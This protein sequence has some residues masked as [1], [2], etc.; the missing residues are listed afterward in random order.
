MNRLELSSDELPEEIRLEAWNDTV[1]WH[2]RP[3]SKE[4]HS[5]RFKASIAPLGPFSIRDAETSAAISQSNCG[6]QRQL[7]D[8]FQVVKTV[9]GGFRHV[10]NGDVIEAREGDILFLRLSELS[11]SYNE[12]RATRALTGPIDLLNFDPAK[13]QNV[14]RFPHHDPYTAVVGAALDHTAESFPDRSDASSDAVS[15]SI[16]QMVN[17]LVLNDRTSAE[18]ISNIAQ[19]RQR[20]A[21]E[22]IERNLAEPGL[23]V[24]MV[25]DHMRVSRATLARDFSEYGG[26]ANYIRNVRL[27][28]AMVLLKRGV[29]ARGKVSLVAEESGFWDM[30]HFNRAF[31]ARFGV[32]PKDAM[33][34]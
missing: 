21:T 33:N 26:L 29:P 11:F 9:S 10:I 22:F 1:P 27:D 4:A 2:T 18:G 17:G 28:K 31:R 24:A 25:S 30:S 15:G 8:L 34:L 12:D 7:G 13:H 23:N 32:S 16:S 6:Q 19:F 14:I 20:A 5:F 3:V